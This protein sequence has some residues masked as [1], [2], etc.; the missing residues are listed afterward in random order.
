MTIRVAIQHETEYQ[1]DRSIKMSPHVLRLRPAVHSRTPIH[2][3]TLKIEPE[4]HFINWQQDPFGNF[5]AR[6][7]FPEKT[8]KFSFKV[9]V[10]A[11]LVAINPFDFF[12]EEYAE[13]FP[14]E[15]DDSLKKELSP[16]LEVTED[17]PLIREWVARIN[18]KKRSIND[19]L[20]E[21][22]QKLEEAIG[23]NIR[24]EPGIQ[25]CEKTLEI[26]KGSC[27]DTSW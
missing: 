9:E 22:N 23:Y 4:N 7:V 24:L 27:R 2:A 5:M 14:F 19:F 13:N 20:V 10:I 26:A 16:F 17:G 8:R 12:V 18:T 6:L 21:Q 1:F 11:D 25:S 15:Y 3:Y